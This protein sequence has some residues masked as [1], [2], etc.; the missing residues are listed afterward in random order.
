[1]MV[2]GKTTV[3]YPASQGDIMDYNGDMRANTDK[4]ERS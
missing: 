1:M 4:Q 3:F 2:A